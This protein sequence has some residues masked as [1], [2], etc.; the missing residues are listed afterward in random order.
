MKCLSLLVLL[1]GVASAQPGPP[2][3]PDTGGG[4]TTTTTT[5]TP[6][7]PTPPPPP[8][9]HPTTPVVQPDNGD[10]DRPEG[11]SFALGVGYAIPTSLQTPN[12][13][14]ARLRLG[15]GFTFEPALIISN[16]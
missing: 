11:L 10:Q 13:T 12:I 14:T 16:G 15:S 8:P 1:G 9:P 3:P 7:E 2:P 4:T 5:T 6:T